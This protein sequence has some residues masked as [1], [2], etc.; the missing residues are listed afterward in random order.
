VPS[1]SLRRDACVEKGVW[2]RLSAILG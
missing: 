1:G 2:N